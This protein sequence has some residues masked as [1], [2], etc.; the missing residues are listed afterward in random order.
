MVAIDKLAKK[1]HST[2]KNASFKRSLAVFLT[3]K[4]LH[5]RPH[6]LPHSP[7]WLLLLVGLW[8]CQHPSVPRHPRQKRALQKSRSLG[9]RGQFPKPLQQLLRLHQ[10]QLQR[11]QPLLWDFWKIKNSHKLYTNRTL[12]YPLNWEV[13]LLFN[14]KLSQHF[15]LLKNVILFV[16][17]FVNKDTIE[18]KGT[19]MT[20]EGFLTLFEPPWLQLFEHQTLEQRLPNQIRFLEP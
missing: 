10:Q 2:T 3:N 6:P 1:T 18:N 12:F 8:F 17:M 15:L 13:K 14:T 19:Q 7:F 16:H 5:P 4:V 20:F 9:C 11:Q